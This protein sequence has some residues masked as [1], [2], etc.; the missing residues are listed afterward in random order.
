VS[1]LPPEL[2]H[3]T[4]DLPPDKAKDVEA[5]ILSS[6]YLVEQ[7][8]LAVQQDHG[9]VKRIVI[10]NNPNE[11]GHFDTSD[12]TIHIK[13]EAF[14]YAKLSDRYDHLVTVIGHETGHAIMS[15]AS[16]SSNAHL[17]YAVQEAANRGVPSVD[18]TVPVSQYFAHTRTDE[19]FAE[20]MSMNAL[21]SRIEH[22]KSAF[23]QQAFLERMDK[24]SMCVENGALHPGIVMESND[25]ISHN[26]HT[27]NFEAMQ[28]CQYD[29]PSSLGKH[30]DSNY[31]NYYGA[32]AL[33]IISGELDDV[34][35]GEIVPIVK[36]DLDRL[37]LSARQLERNGLDMDGQNLT[38]V[39]ISG[40]KQ[41]SVTFD[42]STKGSKN[43]PDTEIESSIAQTPKVNPN[44]PASIE[45][46]PRAIDL[47]APKERKVYEQALT[48]ANRLGL[49]EDQTQNLAMSMT[50]RA[51]GNGVIKQIDD[52]TVVRGRADDGGDRLHMMF[53]PHGD[54]DPAFNDYVDL[55]QAVT[56]PAIE[57][58][59]Q[60]RELALTKEQEA[61]DAAL[62]Q[63]QN[64]PTMKIGGRTIGPA[65]GDSSGG[66]G[67]GGGE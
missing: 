27:A 51:T 41:K 57:S 33:E 36:L 10:S 45:T 54:R 25:R 20:V 43:N 17:Q 29:L 47:L 31:R 63:S 37:G 12:N 35:K 24:F 58:A 40:G 55:N 46:S 9:N 11:G 42:S 23:N 3:L 32:H 49:P 50:H 64:G 19:G 5:A 61:R 53:K 6:P 59:T 39:D 52:I 66:D 56:K 1:K 38:I 15:G 30:G 48:Q 62:T 2:E 34:R 26:L 60:T 65:D 67:G 16:Y 21:A 14:Q 4:K 28:H 18:L 8:K 44:S 7:L 22:T 13:P